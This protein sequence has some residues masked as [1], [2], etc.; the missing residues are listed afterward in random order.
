MACDSAGAG[1]RSRCSS[2]C[3][4]CPHAD[5]STRRGRRRRW[6]LRPALWC[7]IAC[8]V[9]VVTHRKVAFCMVYGLVGMSVGAAVGICCSPAPSHLALLQSK[10]GRSCARRRPARR[11]TRWRHLWPPTHPR[12]P[13]LLWRAAWQAA[14]VLLHKRRQRH[15]RSRRS[16]PCWP[17]ALLSWMRRL[18]SVRSR[19]AHSCFRGIVREPLVSL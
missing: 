2:L 7:A 18:A 10:T 13:W 19:W 6:A 4:H 8:V 17:A 3:A 5:C 14:T 11:T 15:E 12:W 16:G 9:V 1:E